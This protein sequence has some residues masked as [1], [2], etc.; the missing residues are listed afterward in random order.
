M[1]LCLP[2]RR[3]ELFPPRA[4]M[5]GRHFAAPPR[6]LERVR[7]R[8]TETSATETRARGLKRTK[9]GRAGGG[10]RYRGF[11]R[12]IQNSTTL[13]ASF[14]LPSLSPPL[15]V[16]SPP[17][18]PF[19]PLLLS[20]SLFPIASVSP[21]LPRHPR[22]SSFTS[23]DICTGVYA[24]EPVIPAVSREPSNTEGRKGDAGTEKEAEREGG[25]GG[26]DGGG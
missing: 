25:E 22:S 11:K 19:P 9:G 2:V 23:L 6:G 17:P 16:P 26:C 3:G 7:A 1:H 18:P 4:R 14:L 21:S 13:L 5:N 8:G 15:S 20:F 12:Q 24:G 10:L